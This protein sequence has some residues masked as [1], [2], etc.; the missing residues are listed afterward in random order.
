MLGQVVDVCGLGVVEASETPLQ[1][2]AAST[3]EDRTRL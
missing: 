3:L 1:I 2:R